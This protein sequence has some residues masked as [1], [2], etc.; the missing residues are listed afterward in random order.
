MEGD[1][2]HTTSAPTSDGEYKLWTAKMIVH[3]EALDPWR[4]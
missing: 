1:I 2:A 3:L 4:H